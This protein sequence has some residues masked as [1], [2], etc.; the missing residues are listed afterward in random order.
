MKIKTIKLTGT[1]T[2]I[3]FDK[4][5]AFI[6]INNLSGNEILVSAK[7]EIVRGNDDV[8]IVSAKTIVTM[9]DTGSLGIKKIYALGEGEIQLVGKNFA[10]HCFKLPASGDNSDVP[11]VLKFLPHPEGIYAYWDVENNVENF[12]WTDMVG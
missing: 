11:D 8:I 10:Q 9:G 7:P 5:Y 12:T 1:E 6:E 2:E 4:N 3:K